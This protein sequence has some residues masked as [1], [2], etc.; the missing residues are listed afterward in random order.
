VPAE[1]IDDVVTEQIAVGHGV[2]PDHRNGLSLPQWKNSSI[3]QEN[4]RLEGSVEVGRLMLG[5]VDGAC[6]NGGVRLV[7][8]WV[9][10]PGYEPFV[11]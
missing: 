6:T 1:L 2:R 11:C 9:G 3:L 10:Q 7:L 4:H 5:R 8:E